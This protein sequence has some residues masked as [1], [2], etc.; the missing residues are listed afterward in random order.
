M[1][2]SMLQKSMMEHRPCVSMKSKLQSTAWIFCSLWETH[3]TEF[4]ASCQS[5]RTLCH[6]FSKRSSFQ[7]QPPSQGQTSARTLRL[8]DSQETVPQT[9]KQRNT[10]ELLTS[11]TFFPMAAGKSFPLLLIQVGQNYCRESLL[12]PSP[13][14]QCNPKGEMVSWGPPAV[15]HLISLLSMVQG[16]VSRAM[17]VTSIQLFCQ[18][19]FH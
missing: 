3:T 13:P 7:D 5:L 10:M 19:P 18:V 8:P 9:Q 16:S 12:L 17:A 2:L 15:L 14:V 6:F 4:P 11:Q 1:N